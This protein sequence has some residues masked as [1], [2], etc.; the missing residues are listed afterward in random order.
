MEQLIEI[1]I[2]SILPTVIATLIT[3]Y[4]T[5]RV[6]G[7]IKNKFDQKIES[8]KNGYNTELTRLNAELD[9]INNQNNFKFSK[10]HEKRFE[11]LELL[12][13]AFNRKLRKLQNYISPVKYKPEHQTFE[14]YEDELYKNYYDN[15]NEF[16]T[17]FTDNKIFL[18]E[19]IIE[20]IDSYLKEELEIFHAYYENHFLTRTGDRPNLETRMKAVTAY[21]KVPEKISPILKEIE[22]EFK[23]L[24]ER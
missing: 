4:I 21:K 19:K 7:S 11:I 12:Y 24:L 13:K 14:E 18:N 5:E 3:L 6:K 9:L 10:L 16:V 20:L 23:E 15:H 2:L 8:I 1:L 22:N 17:L